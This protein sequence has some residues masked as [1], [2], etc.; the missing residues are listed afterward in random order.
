MTLL[1]SYSCSKCAGVLVF[2][3][4]QEFFDCPFCGTTYKAGAFHADE[5]F[6]QAKA[7]LEQKAFEIAKEKY[8]LILADDPHNFD[9][10]SGLVLCAA[11][12]SSVDELKDP[13]SLKDADFDA[14]RT[15]IKRARDN[16]ATGEALYFENLQALSDQAEDL[17]KTR[18]VK[19][20]VSSDKA[21]EN[22]RLSSEYVSKAERKNKAYN[23]ELII[24]AT[25]LFA[26]GL[27]LSFIARH[28][29]S[30]I[31]VVIAIF[32]YVLAL[33]AVRELIISN[34]KLTVRKMPYREIAREGRASEL[35]ASRK[36]AFELEQYQK[37][38]SVL[39]RSVPENKAAPDLEEPAVHI[40]EIISSVN[41][42][43]DITCGKCG[44]A[45]SLDRSRRVYSCS[46]CG[47]AY[48]ISL[49]FGYPLEKALNAL[50][51]GYFAEADSR[52]RHVL[53]KDA[54]D[55]DALLGRILC[56]GRWTKMSD[57][58]YSKDISVTVIRELEGL[59]KEAAEHAK[60][61]D[62]EFFVSAKELTDVLT[63]LMINRHRQ[64]NLESGLDK[65]DTLQKAYSHTYY[66]GDSD[67]EEMKKEIGNDQETLRNE[68]E[69]IQERF[70]SV[71]KRMMEMKSDSVFCK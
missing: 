30:V 4:D 44:A 39:L 50:N 27:T 23:I 19:N 62:K 24:L 52:F 1:K 70:D 47:V 36:E 49:F 9:A 58:G 8:E 31:C 61:A 57:I 16:S 12:V 53:M 43:N 60:D 41:D 46:H 42:E 18:E 20:E 25:V 35:H 21:K 71:R 69:K 56:R 64:D 38:Y 65:I 54:S 3:N 33:F 45:L 67:P 17:K 10:L 55:F 34:L 5:I 32:F 6:S 48:G 14:V 37:K 28:A 29:D 59:I 68:E 26:V 11:G 51:A 22:V 66:F 7:S 40:E 2:D 13:G 15:A 63:K